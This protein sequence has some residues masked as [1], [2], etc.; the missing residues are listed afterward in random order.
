MLRIIVTVSIAFLFFLSGAVLAIV[1]DHPR[2]L[3]IEWKREIR[4]ALNLEKFWKKVPT[5]EVAVERKP[6]ACPGYDDT[7]VLVTGGQSN[8][9][10]SNTSLSNVSPKA[11]VYL[12]FNGS[13]YI[14]NDPMLGAT[15]NNGS[16][17]PE[18][19]EALHDRLDR[20]ILFINGAIGGSQ[21]EDWLDLRS[22]YYKALLDRI[23]SAEMA[24]F[25]SDL[26]FW[27]QGETD[28]N[29]IRDQTIMEDQLGEMVDRLLADA[30][31]AHL[32][33]FQTSKCTGAYRQNGVEHIRAAQRVVASQRDRVVEGMNTDIL[34]N[35][36]RWDTCHFNSRGREAIIDKIIPDI[37]KILGENQPL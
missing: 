13:C 12:W 21:V 17:W 6:T 9:A 5:E 28:A 35:D 34:G 25:G 37:S 10:N 18:L 4:V 29:I 23:E 1:S 31:N 27:H 20:P 24:G 16:L 26:I 36:F 32:Y 7:L 14:A 8:A 15:G 30:P 19:G 33:L 3:Y 11:Q 22:G 2:T